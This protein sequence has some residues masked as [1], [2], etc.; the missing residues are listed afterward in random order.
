MDFD[1]YQ[2]DAAR[3]INTQDASGELCNHALGLAGE[4]GEVV[5]IVKK[6]V[7]HG[8][9]LDD[10]R[11]AEEIGDVLWYVAA[12]CSSRG[13]SLQEVAESNIA[14]LRARY[15]DGFVKQGEARD[16]E[17]ALLVDVFEPIVETSAKQ[18]S[19]AIADRWKLNVRRSAR[20]ALEG[21]E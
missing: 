2:K 7:F 15:P 6:H 19:Y 18:E 8:K 9:A 1:S 12:V 11:L 14:K 10:A 17:G 20:Q 16:K 5:E 4:T 3:T 13:L 21:S